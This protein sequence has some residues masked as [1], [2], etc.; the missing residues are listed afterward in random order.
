MYG[1]RR[2]CTSDDRVTLPDARMILQ[3]S[4]THRLSF[5]TAR[6]STATPL[7]DPTISGPL[8]IA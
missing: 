5:R 6:R 8:I 4:T 1:F 3:G 7:S 2:D